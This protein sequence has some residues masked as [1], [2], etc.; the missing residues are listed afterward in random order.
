M[1][2]T[3][4]GN[5]PD[6]P[7]RQSAP[8]ANWLQTHRSRSLSSA[9][10]ASSSKVPAASASEASASTA[11]HRG[12]KR[13]PADQLTEKESKQ[14]ERN[15]R[16][17]AKRRAKQSQQAEESLASDIQPASQAAVDSDQAAAQHP[18][19][20]GPRQQSGLP[21]RPCGVWQQ[22]CGFVAQTHFS[23]SRRLRQPTTEQDW[24]ACVAHARTELKDIAV[25]AV[26]CV[27]NRLP[28]QTQR[29]YALA[30]CMS[31]EYWKLDA[32][33]STKQ[34]A[35]AV[36]SIDVA[37]LAAELAELAGFFNQ[38]NTYTVG[39]GQ[40]TSAAKVAVDLQRDVDGTAGNG[41]RLLV[42]Q[43]LDE[44]AKLVEHVKGWPIIGGKVRAMVDCMEFWGSW[45]R[46]VF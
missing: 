41:E 6:A 28:E 32:S 16:A 15:D 27:Q 33:V 22:C 35:V 24:P 18:A 37:Q 40:H 4:S 11:G 9:P 13:K 21:P 39:G 31:L 25:L 1:S 45:C 19:D 17:Y 3:G 34:R 26:A 43:L 42:P 5:E 8:H 23:S 36:D 2:A 30:T 10:S 7:Q 46:R 14:Q 44:A 12:R 20:G 29:I 38:E